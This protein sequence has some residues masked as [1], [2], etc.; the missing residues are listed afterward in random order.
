MKKLIIGLLVLVSSLSFMSAPVYAVDVFPGCSS[1]LATTDVCGEVKNQ[2][3][4][5]TNPIISILKTVI[6]IISYFIGVIAVIVLIIAGIQMI[7]SGGNAQSVAT[8]RNSM[9]YALVGI[10]VAVLAQ[11]IVAFVLDKIG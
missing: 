7:T 6:S 9:I 10:L 5:G 11:V 1:N 4:S 8:A 3:S 2:T